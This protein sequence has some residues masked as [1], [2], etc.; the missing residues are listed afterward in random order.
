LAE[1]Q[2]K[3]MKGSRR[4]PIHRLLLPK[5]KPRLSLSA[6][7]SGLLS[8]SQQWPSRYE[9]PSWWPA[10]PVEELA[11]EQ[12]ALRRAVKTIRRYET[13]VQAQMVTKKKYGPTSRQVQVGVVD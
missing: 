5:S 8:V 7:A 6:V 1:G 13:Q 2:V 4:R 10:W 12:L 3:Q 9:T 11:E